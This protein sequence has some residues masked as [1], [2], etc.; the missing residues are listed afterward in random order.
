M[1]NAAEDVEAGDS[2]MYTGFKMI[3]NL[4]SFH[5]V[6]KKCPQYE[7]KEERKKLRQENRNGHV[8]V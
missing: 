8:G 4:P 3:S 6:R 5:R 2:R 1:L 7:E